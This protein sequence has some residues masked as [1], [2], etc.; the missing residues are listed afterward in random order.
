[1]VTAAA[2]V[3]SSCLVSPC[4]PKLLAAAREVVAFTVD[5]AQAHMRLD[6]FVSERAPY[7]TR[8]RVQ[9][10]IESGAVQLEARPARGSSRMR[11][12]ERVTVVIDKRP[13]DLEAAMREPL[14]LRVLYE[15]DGLI[16]VDKPAHVASHPAGGHV[17]RTALTWLR[18]A[19]PGAD[20]FPK[21]C[22]RLDRETSGVLLA[23]K[24]HAAHREAL[25]LIAHGALQKQY[26]A[27]VHGIVARDAF[28]I[29]LPLDEDGVSAVTHKRCARA[30]GREPARTAAAVERRLAGFTLV[31]LAP[32]T[33]RRH[34]LRVHLSALGHP[35]VGDKLY[36]PGEDRVF[37]RARSGRLTAADRELLLLDRHALHASQIE[38]PWWG[39]FLS[40]TA[41]WPDELDAF[42]RTHSPTRD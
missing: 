42:V 13:R 26:R 35:I 17:H 11:A 41:P 8:T 24:T 18:T 25:A 14:A 10:L 7:L 27:I 6:V 4:D 39:H 2:A 9:K 22:H 20:G 38:L 32:R 37:L 5:P 15:D 21:L 28:E 12:G 40:V 33:G 30:G 29:D 19:R 36:G 3:R 1:M 23:A 34:Q 16:A 31:R